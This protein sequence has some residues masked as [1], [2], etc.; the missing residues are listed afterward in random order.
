VKGLTRCV[1]QQD[2]KQLQIVEFM[3][4]LLSQTFMAAFMVIT[5]SISNLQTMKIALMFS[6][7]CEW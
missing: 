5:R 4:N 1:F 3:M 6:A 2:G 7:F